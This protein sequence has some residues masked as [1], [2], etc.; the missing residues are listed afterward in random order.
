M[1]PSEGKLRAA[2]CPILLIGHGT[3]EAD[4]I[5]Q[6]QEC[7]KLVAA[8][9]PGRV[10]RHAFLELA[11]PSIGAALAQMPLTRPAN[12][13][14]ALVVAP[15]LLFTGG[16]AKQDIPAAVQAAVGDLPWRQTPALELHPKILELSARRFRA[17]LDGP[18]VGSSVSAARA[19][20]DDTLLWFIGRGGTDREAL[21]RCREFA[22]LRG[23]LTPV[24]E[25]RVGFMVGGEPTF[26]A[27]I[28][29]ASAS[30]HS[31]VVVQ[32]HFL[33]AGTLSRQLS[34]C[35]RDAA[36]RTPGKSWWFAEPLGNDPR[37]VDCLV[38]LVHQTDHRPAPSRPSSGV[39]SSK[40]S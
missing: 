1:T 12:G 28:A 39:R 27:A 16:H 38:D 18:P 17:A 21:D 5:A 32:P 22:E 19:R 11:E 8:R 3:R 26:R 4:G 2:G 24:E 34:G 23:R 9:F 36:A 30:P 29:L 25:L 37:L 35:V 31:A 33:F 6:F 10:V 13:G 14:P 15:L 20:P 40:A 7:A